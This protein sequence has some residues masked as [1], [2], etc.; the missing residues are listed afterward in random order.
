MRA[1]TAAVAREVGL[2][3]RLFP[4]WRPPA[5]DAAGRLRRRRTN[6]SS[7]GR[8]GRRATTSVGFA[9]AERESQTQ[10]DDQTADAARVG[11][12]DVRLG[13]ARPERAPV[14]SLEEHRRR[15]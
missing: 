13:G 12:P 9:R 3:R 10:P 4:R 14:V 1:R 7:G 6:T 15:D 8:G 5:V 11:A 2:D